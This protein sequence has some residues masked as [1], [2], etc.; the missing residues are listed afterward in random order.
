MRAT[1]HIA[2]IDRHGR[3]RSSS[4]DGRTTRHPG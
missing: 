2:Q 1:P 4:I 3:Q